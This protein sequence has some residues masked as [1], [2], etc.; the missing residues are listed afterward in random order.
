MLFTCYNSGIW[1]GNYRG[2]IMHSPDE[3]YHESVI[4]DKLLYIFRRAV[5][6]FGIQ[7]R[8]YVRTTNFV[9]LSPQEIELQERR[10][11]ITVI[12]RIGKHKLKKKKKKRPSS[13]FL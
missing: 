5:A 3:E 12:C 6:G 9:L 1:T 4:Q 13:T 10:I 7:A 2:Q 8:L 11:T